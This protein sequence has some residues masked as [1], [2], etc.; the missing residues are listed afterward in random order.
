MET[1]WTMVAIKHEKTGSPIK[2]VT[3]KTIS[4][5]RARLDRD[6]G[7]IAHLFSVEQDEPESEPELKLD[8]EE[9]K[10]R[11]FRMMVAEDENGELMGFNWATRSRFDAGQ[12]YF[13]VIVKAE[14][15]RQ[16]VGSRLY[17]DLE[18]AA[19][20]AKVKQLQV[21]LRDRDPACRAFAEKRGFV[22]KSHSLGLALD[23][24]GFD[25]SPYARTIDRLKGQGFRFTSMEALG[26]T[27][28]VQ[29]R[30]YHLN[31]STEMEAVLPEDNHSWLSFEDFQ[32]KVC[33]A[34]WY[35]PAGQL[36]AIDNN[37]GAWAA[38]SAITRYAGA[39]YATNLHTGVD[40]RYHRRGLA[41]AMLALALR[42]AKESLRVSSV[43]AD[44]DE[45]N[46]PALAIYTAMGYTRVEGSIAMEKEI[47]D[48]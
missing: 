39:D 26:N 21:N 7:Q 47:T 3:M 27:P 36:V 24:S 12:A 13:Y 29:R 8:Y 19:K 40:R 17:A 34:D 35:I 18:Q 32:R 20:E 42:Y 44:E 16:G 6:F 4:L 11:I 10:A 37:T 31:D 48:L 43:R 25:D 22:E 41:Q 45:Q 46:V 15:R 33:Q 2:G 9:H 23:L 1:Q 14:C 28:E 38:M 30:L 5:R